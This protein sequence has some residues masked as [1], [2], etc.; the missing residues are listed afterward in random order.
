MQ[1]Y[2]FLAGIVTIIYLLITVIKNKFIKEHN[3][4]QTFCDICL[5]FLSVLFSGLALSFGGIY[6]LTSIT[7][8]N[9]TPAFTSGPDF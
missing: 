9:T 7:A 8:K 5:V 6:E 4:N 1:E 3:E 2:F